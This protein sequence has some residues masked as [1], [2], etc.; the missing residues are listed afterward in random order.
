M[1]RAAIVT[2]ASSGMGFAIART[3][4]ETGH[5]VTM[6]ARRPD[7]LEAAGKTLRNKGHD[8]QELA[9]NLRDPEAPVEV[10]ARHKEAY[11]RL[12]VLVNN[13]GVGDG[14]PIEEQIDKYVDLVLAVNLRA[15]VQ[16]YREATPM[17]RAAAEEHHNAHVI[18]I[19]S[20]AAKRPA[21]LVSVY[22]ATK[23]GVVAFT[24]AMNKELGHLGIKSCALCPGFVDTEMTAWI[25][26]Q[27][28]PS[29]MI[30]PE[31]V[32]GAVRWLLTT[33]PQCVVPEIQ[34]TR[35]GDNE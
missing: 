21:A 4:A 10:V 3:L 22:S 19:A 28:P 14:R 12:D 18:N 31:D 17:L 9:L 5:A 24:Q 33:S 32:A 26:D 15:V 30:Q 2:G 6:V 35:P 8:V 7:K 13:A 11:G 16:F 34:F 1:D 25:R 23:A 20:I 27:V 29:D